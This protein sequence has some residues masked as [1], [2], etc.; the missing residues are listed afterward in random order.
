M[1]SKN[2]EKDKDI[3]EKEKHLLYK[4]KHADIDQT[5]RQRL[6]YKSSLAFKDEKRTQKALFGGIPMRQEE[7][8]STHH[9]S[10]ANQTH[11]K[12]R[13]S[14]HS[15]EKSS[16]VVS[17]DH[18]RHGASAHFSNKSMSAASHHQQSGSSSHSHSKPSGS[19]QNKQSQSSKQGQEQKS[20]PTSSQSF[21][22]ALRRSIP[23]SRTSA[24]S[25]TVAVAVLDSS[26]P[27]KVIEALTH[28][29]KKHIKE[30]RNVSRFRELGGLDK[31]LS[32]IQRPNQ[33]MIDI[34]LSILGNICTDDTIRKQVI[35]QTFIQLP[36]LLRQ[37]PF[38]F[39]VGRAEDIMKKI[40]VPLFAPPTPHKI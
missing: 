17:Y 6:G 7:G 32:L 1:A 26:K 38:D 34:S 25:L 35:I 8:P 2:Q 11:K 29:R 10:V 40:F 12:H 39:D 9:T 23:D 31:L 14:S 30:A 4:V 36:F 16:T 22:K 20:T 13:S 19:H 3:S 18:K 5:Q 37:L 24:T 33:T 15:G 28:I 27:A 21:D